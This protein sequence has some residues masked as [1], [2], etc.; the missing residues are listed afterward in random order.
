VPES[1]ASFLLKLVPNLGKLV[2][3]Y[4]LTDL[5]ITNKIFSWKNKNLVEDRF[6]FVNVQF[7]VQKLVKVDITVPYFFLPTPALPIPTF[8]MTNRIQVQ[9]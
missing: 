9:L 2:N 6:L 5:H 4:S 8:I 7:I 1:K 3:P